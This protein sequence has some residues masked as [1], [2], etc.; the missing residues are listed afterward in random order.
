MRVDEEQTAHLEQLEAWQRKTVE[1]LQSLEERI[2]QN[3][4]EIG[5]CS[6]RLWQ[7]WTEYIQTQLAFLDSVVKRR[8][9]G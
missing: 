2:E 9:A 4:Q 1:T 5:T 6:D 7:T 3:R 8:G